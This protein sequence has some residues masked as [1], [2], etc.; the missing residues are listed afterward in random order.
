MNE[1]LSRY[2]VILYWTNLNYLL[3]LQ[4]QNGIYYLLILAFPLLSLWNV[5]ILLISN[6]KTH[7][8]VCILQT[9]FP[10]LPSKSPD[11]SFG[12]SQS[13]YHILLYAVL[14][15]ACILV[16]LKIVNSSRLGSM[17]L[18]LEIWSL[19]FCVFYNCGTHWRC[20][21]HSHLH[22]L[23]NEKLKSINISTFSSPFTLQIPTMFFIMS[24]IDWPLSFLLFS[25]HYIFM[26]WWNSSLAW[27][28][29]DP[30]WCVFRLK[31]L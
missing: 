22:S 10:D 24:I 31:L 3:C 26:M 14:V 20:L 13:I 5:P 16:L 25:V 1:C 9:S 19:P 15:Y 23:V 21:D 18:V 6:C 28:F 30:T 12:Q 4:L 8:K 29:A 27:G 17:S 7:L 11:T 2:S